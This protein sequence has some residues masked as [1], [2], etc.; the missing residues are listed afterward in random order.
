MK[1]AV[2][3]MGGDN[4]P[5]AIIEGVEEARDLYPDLTFDLYGNPDKFTSMIKNHD[6]LNIIKTTEE[7]AMGEEP[8]RAIRKKKDSSIVRAANA[9]KEGNADAFFSAGN[10]GAVLAAGIFIVG[11]IRGIDRPGLTSIL[12]IT[13]PGAK[14][15]SFV[16]LDS[17]ANAE[18]KEKNLVQFAYLGK[19]YAEK[20]LGVTNPRV[21]LLN[22]GAEED[23]G[24]KLHKAVWQLLNAEEELN[25]IGNIESGDL[26]FGKADV[27]VSDGWT[28]N[29]ALKATEGTAKMMLT[30]I[31]D[32]ILNGGLRAKLG[33]LMLKPVF[34]R[35]GQKMSTSTYGGAVLLGLKAPVVKTHGSSDPAAVKNTISQIRTMLKTG[36]VDKTVEFFNQNNE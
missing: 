36:V 31:K 20:V 23:K 32:G 2:D 19:F 7:I 17:G 14:R 35:I 15:Q 29:A 27:V 1:I 28:A 26:L 4:A 9:V 6:R 21:A 22:N 3:A 5:K 33:Y 16:Y 11:R 25:F 10:T 12:P 30:V 8:V 34:H 18:S 13:K 24:D